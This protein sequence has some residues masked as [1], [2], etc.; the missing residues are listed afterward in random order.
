MFNPKT[1]SHISSQRWESKHSSIEMAQFQ[2]G[3]RAKTAHIKNDTLLCNYLKIIRFFYRHFDYKK[4][5]NVFFFSFE[6]Y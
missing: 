1:E 5:K 3:P 4:K 6:C 2:T